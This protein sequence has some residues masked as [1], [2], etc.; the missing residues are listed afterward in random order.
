MADDADKLNAAVLREIVEGTACETGT[1]FFDE[2]VRHLARATGTMCAWV[3]EW[4]PESRSLRALSFWLNDEYVLDFEYAIA[5]TPCEPVVERLD[6]FHVPDQVIDLFPED[7]SLVEIG[8]VSYLGVPLMDTDG[9]LL[10]HLAILDDKVMPEDAPAISIFNIFAG[11]AGAELR[12]LRRDTWLADSQAKLSRLFSSAMDGIVE[13]DHDLRITQLNAAAESTLG[14][15]GEAA[16]GD[17]FDQFLD[18]SSYGK[19]RYLTTELQRASDAK[20]SLWIPDG[21]H[22]LQSDGG[23]FRAEATLSR[24]EMEGDAF[25][26]LIFRDVEERLAAEARIQ[27]LTEE[28]S[29][30][31]AEI[32]SFQDFGDIAGR[33]EPLHRVLTDLKQVAGTDS[34]VLITGETG[35]GKELFAR[36]IH[37]QSRRSERPLIK[38]NCAAIAEG[39]QESEFFGHEKGAF[40]GATERRD[41]RFKL[42]DGGTLFLDEVGEMPLDLQAKLL[43]VLQEGE[44]EPVGSARTEHVDVRVVTATNRE[45]AAMVEEGTFREDLFYRLNVFPLHIPALRERDEDVVLLAERFVEEASRRIGRPGVRL[46]QDDRARLCRYRWPGNVRELHNVLERA[47]ITSGDG[48]RLNLN[49]ALPDTVENGGGSR[50]PAESGSGT[51]RGIL[52]DR[53]MRELERDNIVGALRAAGWKISGPDGAAERLGIRPNTLTSRMK[54][55]GIGKPAGSSETP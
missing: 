28:A 42:A 54:A 16:V 5:G 27:A 20:P 49:R 29:S 47:I 40:T 32:E 35:T 3:T 51:E 17:P 10:G 26:S 14:I 36:E 41:G 12:R 21:I 33:S 1:E 18:E 11:R 24:Y 13:L 48:V 45:L 53:E 7:S 34:T 52:T 39:L 50:S 15:E 30:L 23:A 46:T 31:R 8:P 25:Y 9:T 6:F 43:R 38:V 22:V 44:F 37:R 2:L 19:L 4:L 55:M